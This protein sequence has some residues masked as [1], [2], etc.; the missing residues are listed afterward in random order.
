MFLGLFDRRPMFDHCAVGIDDDRRS[1]RPLHFFAVHHLSAEGIVFSHDLGFRI[2]Q[3]H[4]GQL[5]FL[6]ELVV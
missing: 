4:V 1:Y 6:A 3:Q 2:G 5:M